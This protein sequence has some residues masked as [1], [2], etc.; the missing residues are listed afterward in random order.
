MV[1]R[2]LEDIKKYSKQRKEKKRNNE[3]CKINKS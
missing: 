1:G 2:M 3:G